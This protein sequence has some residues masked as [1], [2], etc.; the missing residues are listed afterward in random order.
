MALG[1]PG[2][3][4]VDGLSVDTSARIAQSHRVGMQSRLTLRAPRSGVYY[5]ELKLSSQTRDPVQ[6]KLALARS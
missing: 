5:I 6:Y 1:R 2:T 4:N 3:Q